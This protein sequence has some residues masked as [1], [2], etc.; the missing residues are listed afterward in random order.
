M[1]SS[2]FKSADKFNFELEKCIEECSTLSDS[3]EGDD[4]ANLRG[5]ITPKCEKT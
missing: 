5:Y 2:S 4:C 1:F 3:T